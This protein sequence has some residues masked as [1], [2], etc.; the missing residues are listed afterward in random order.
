MDDSAINRGQSVLDK[1][2]I[3]LL[4][5]VKPK[6]DGTVNVD[7]EFMPIGDFIASPPDSS[8]RIKN[9]LPASGIG[10]VFGCSHVG[11]SFVL[12]DLACHVALGWDWHGHKTKK[13]SVLYIAAE[14]I[15]G[16]KLRFRA[17]F[18]DHNVEPPPNLRIRT[19]PADLSVADTTAAIAERMARLPERPGLVLIDT[20]AT[21]FGPGSENDVEDMGAAIAGLHTLKGDGLILS[22]HHTGHGDKTR[23][24]GHSSLFAALDV[25]LCVTQDVDKRILVG[26]TKLRD[27]DKKERIAAFE[28]RKVSLPWAD[29]DG[30]PLNSAVLV[31]ADIPDMS[32]LSGQS[33]RLPASQRIALDALRAAL[34]EHGV[35]DKG[36]V[37]VAE[38]QWRQAAYDAGITSVDAT[39]DARRKAFNRARD[40]LVA[41]KKVACFDGRYWIAYTRTKPDKTGQCPDMSG[42]MLDGQTGQNRT[43]PY[44]GCPVV[45]VSGIPRQP[46]QPIQ[47][48]QPDEL[49]PRT[50]KPAPAPNAP[51]LAVEH[52]FSDVGEI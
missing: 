37:S 11:K 13:T 43:H 45:R 9:V 12:I 41:S 46:N 49:R 2:A 34:V 17:W 44:K 27:G 52:D 40:A 29:E 35:E 23:G 48:T 19:I 47:E 16:L 10:Q 22:V 32:G 33:D 25:E 8:Y 21:N 42:G 7:D 18:Q 50:P 24:R 14:G 26:H 3:E 51:P 15:A 31:K 6:A 30:D 28:L 36:V 5:K 20:F 1:K 4:D 38:D 39:Q